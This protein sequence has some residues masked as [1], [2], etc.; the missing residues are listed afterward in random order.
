MK[1]SLIMRAILAFIFLSILSCSRDDA[2][3]P[4]SQ[5]GTLQRLNSTDLQQAIADFNTIRNSRDWTDHQLAADNFAIKLNGRSIS[6]EA[7]RDRAIFLTWIR[8]NLS[9]T[10]WTAETVA[11][12]DYDNLQLL[13]QTL[14]QTL[15][16]F[17]QRLSN[18]D[19]DDV[20]A[21][22]AGSVS[23]PIETTGSDPCI[24]G[25][26]AADNFAVNNL[27]SNYFMEII[28]AAQAHDYAAVTSIKQYYTCMLAEQEVHHQ[29]CLSACA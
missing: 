7:L 28:S 10:R 23:V 20:R 27:N 29:S 25:C 4:H 24:E 16:P 8:S 9:T 26:N 17:I 14:N 6:R 2:P 5:T 15:V 13:A 12:S 21:I 22:F 1:K 11:M 19:I 18:V 3:T